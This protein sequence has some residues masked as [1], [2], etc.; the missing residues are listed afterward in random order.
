[1]NHNSLAITLLSILIFSFGMLSPAIAKSDVPDKVLRMD[2][3]GNPEFRPTKNLTDK[4]LKKYWAK[5]SAM[6]QPYS[7]KKKQQLKSEHPEKCNDANGCK[8][9]Y[10]VIPSEKRGVEPPLVPTMTKPKV[11]DNPK[12]NKDEDPEEGE[13]DDTRSKDGNNQNGRQKLQNLANKPWNKLSDRQKNML[14]QADQELL[15]QYNKLTQC[16]KHWARSGEDR[17]N[18]PNREEIPDIF[19]KL[20]PQPEHPA[21]NDNKN[22]NYASHHN[23]Q[24]NKKLDPKGEGVSAASDLDYRDKEFLNKKR[25][26][27]PDRPATLNAQEEEER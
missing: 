15:E 21:L 11:I 14:C 8:V 20:A 3:N 1:M 7:D 26:L 4:Q 23:R 10:D 9:V 12:T 22:A 18:G 16:Q 17:R 5:E 24:Q 2:E 13:D 6:A 25:D 27:L 19:S